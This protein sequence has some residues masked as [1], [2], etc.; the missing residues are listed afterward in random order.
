MT[1]ILQAN[2]QHSKAATAVLCVS[3]EN[4]AVDFALIQEPWIRNSK[5]AGFGTSRG[6]V[7]S[8]NA[9]KPRTCIWA[10]NGLICDPVLEFCS[11]DQTT[12]RMVRRGSGRPLL[13][14]SVYMPVEDQLPPEET[15]RLVDHAATSGLD[16]VLGCD[17]NAHNMVW[18]CRE[19]NKRGKILL[20]YVA[21]SGLMI[22]NIGS[23]PTF[24]SRVGQSVIDLTLFS[25]GM[26]E[27]ILDWQVSHEPSLS[28][29]RHI[30]F[31][32]GNSTPEVYTFR[33][34]RRTNWDKFNDSIKGAIVEQPIRVRDTHELEQA[35]LTLSGSILTSFEGS[36]PMSVGKKGKVSWWTQELAALRKRVRSL[37]KRAKV[38]NNWDAYHRLLT[39]YNLAIRRAKRLSW[40]RFCENLEGVSEASR[41]HKILAKDRVSQLGSLEGPGG[42]LIHDAG[43]VLRLMGS[44]HFPGCIFLNQQAAPDIRLEESRRAAPSSWIAASRIVT[45]SKIR[46]AV[47]SLSP[48]KSPGPDGIRPICL[49]QGIEHLLPV[50]CKLFRAS[51]ALGHI[52]K[53]WRMSRVVFIPKPGKTRYTD[54]KSFRP[55]SLTSFMLKTLEKVVLRHVGDTSLKVNPLHENQHAYIP[56][57]SCDSALHHLVGRIEKVLEFKEVAIGAF[58]D[59]QGAFDNTE[60]RAVMRASRTHGLPEVVCRWTEAL[61]THR[62][63]RLSLHGESVE[64][65]ATR[66]CPQGGVL[67]PLL[68]NLVVD[69]LI[70][71][72]NS[73]GVYAQGYADD[74]AILVAGKFNNTVTDLMNDALR[75][76]DQWCQEVGL[77]VNPDKV[78]VVPFTRR[79]NLTGIGPFRLQGTGVELQKK[80]KYLGVTLDQTLHWGPH[81]QKVIDRGKWSL[82][83]CRRLVGGTWGL[84]PMLL[85]W[86]FVSVVRPSL[87][88]GAIA[89]WTKMETTSAVTG[90]AGVQRLAGLITTGAVSSC[91]GASLDCILDIT[92]ID[93]HIKTVARKTAYRLQCEGLWRES[94]GSYGHSR[95]M[96]VVQ[97][98]VLVMPSD[99]MPTRHF[100]CKPFEVRIPGRE[101]WLEGRRPLPPCNLEWY[102]DGSKVRA[103]TGAGFMEEQSCV[104]LCIPMGVHPTVFQAEVT[105]IMECARENLRAGVRGASI[106][107]FSDSQAALKALSSCEFKS[108]LVWDCLA[109]VSAL[110]RLNNVT[111]CWVPGHTGIRGNEV[112]DELANVASATTMIGPQPFCGISREYACRIVKAWAHDEHKRRWA[113]QPRLRVSKLT[114]HSPSRRVAKAILQLDRRRSRQIVGMVTGHGHLRKH[115]SR[116]GI[117][118]GD[119]V[120]RKCGQFEETAD[121]LLFDCRELAEVRMTALGA[122]SRG[123]FLPQEELVDRL[124]H[125]I[126]LLGL[127]GF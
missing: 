126:G 99:H 69:D 82:M 63:V 24:H 67:S 118:N 26:R 10:R 50:M 106:C 38:N 59:I 7:I 120:C 34:P 86:L 78:V 42:M 13:L 20:E 30:L 41:I 109:T 44:T 29:H 88:Y 25:N 27:G 111:L 64:L 43:E 4:G 58:L 96:Q 66:G 46:W 32:V 5:I 73:S 85:H 28:D 116:L 48:Y 89:W 22:A 68:W 70:R 92:P 98:E 19:T 17:T 23:E 101:E 53:V 51:L 112:A 114:L 115:L 94:G 2:L 110:G 45:V 6:Q 61:L 103:G 123:S 93:L 40:T 54:P 72:L 76:V 122:L 81:L 47:K 100:F 14:A 91:P 87:T 127:D 3:T 39:Q 37:F 125:F 121:H 74:V 35:A 97:N 8:H 84:K 124:Q 56:G 79:R 18:G 9:D 117:Y 102:T 15:R 104:R 52:P 60:T 95:I 31:K 33:N 119:P 90:L 107:I 12:V 1:R 75:L 16:L 11:R 21:S 57:R 65:K 62:E 77:S 55:V 108:K 36:C 71:M 49:Q 80:V 83:T 113:N 105:A